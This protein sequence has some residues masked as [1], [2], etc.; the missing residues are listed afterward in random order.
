[1]TVLHT[2]PSAEL[3]ALVDELPPEGREDELK[4]LR[5][6][7]AHLRELRAE[8]GDLTAR[9]MQITKEITEITTKELPDKFQELGVPLLGLE[10]HGNLPGLVATLK[11]FYRA[12]IAASWDH[13]QREAGFNVLRRLDAADLI[14]TTVTVE[15]GRGKHKQLE[16]LLKYLYMNQDLPFSTAQS[17]HSGTLTAWLKGR[18]K[19]GAEPSPG[20]LAA[21]GGQVGR[22]VEVKDAKI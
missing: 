7:L 8:F 21:I 3:T 19:A 17:A 4:K 20:D 18:C 11:P 22:V 10:A 2:A 12:G 6:R 9:L 15:L 14:K 1:M 16:G 5:A 13:E